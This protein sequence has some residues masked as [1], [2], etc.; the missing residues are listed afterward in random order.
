VRA[1]RI[2]GVS[3]SG[4][5]TELGYDDG[6]FWEGG[7]PPGPRHLRYG[8]RRVP[9]VSNAVTG[10]VDS[11]TLLTKV[12]ALDVPRG[13][14]RTAYDW[15]EVETRS[16]LQA[17]SFTLT[18]GVNAPPRGITFRTL[19]RGERRVRVLVGACSQWHGYE[20]RRLYLRLERAQAL[21]AVRL[22]R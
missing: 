21:A 3:R 9:V 20:S 18:D 19:A 8:G 10:F 17:N 7:R 16:P 15:F 2:Y 12:I 13:V 4:E 22:Y 11:S 14:Q 5:A 6:T 1:V